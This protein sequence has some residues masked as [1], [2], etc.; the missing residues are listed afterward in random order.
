MGGI[1]G[2]VASGNIT[3]SYS[4]L[5]GKLNAVSTAG[6]ASIGGI[7]GA[8]TGNM[9]RAKAAIGCYSLSNCTATS[10]AGTAAMNGALVGL[11]NR[12]TTLNTCF[13]YSDN[14]TF[15]GHSG[16]EGTSDIYRL[17]DRETATLENAAAAMNEILIDYNSR[18]TYD[19]Q[20]GWLTVSKIE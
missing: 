18:Y 2:I 10:S 6:N 17:A 14:D 11:S 20:T 13:W 5:D 16:A 4:I 3:G 9:M 12:N 7:A 8:M 15:T 1:A 19:S